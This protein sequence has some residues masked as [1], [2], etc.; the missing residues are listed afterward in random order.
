MQVLGHKNIKNTLLYVQLA[1][2]LF[3]DQREFVSK[4]AKME[5]DACELVE[6]GFEYV[7]DFNGSK[8]FRKSKCQPRDKPPSFLLTKVRGVGFEPYL[9]WR[10]LP[11]FLIFM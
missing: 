6:A 1:E 3:K 10:R 11:Q 2:Q 7:C 4:V 9:K 5:K 8:I